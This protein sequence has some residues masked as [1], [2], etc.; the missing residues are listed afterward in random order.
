MNYRTPIGYVSR[1]N[2]SLYNDIPTK[3]IYQPYVYAFAR[4]IGERA[5]L[6]YIIDIGAGS[7]EKLIRF[8]DQFKIIAIDTPFGI[9]IARK[10]IPT[11]EFIVHDLE[12]GL[13]EIQIEIL[14]KSIIIFSDVIEHI[15]NPEKILRQLAEISR[16]APYIL[17]STPDRDRARG[18]LDMG[19]PANPAHVREWNGTEL[20]R[21]MLDCG[22]DDVP[23]YGHTINTDFHKAKSTLL[24]ISGSHATTKNENIHPDLKVVA[25]IH[26]FNES[27]IL[28]ET[29]NHLVQ[30]GI[31]VHYFDN[32]STDGSWELAHSFFE[33]GLIAHCERFPYAPTN[34]YEWHNQLEKTENYALQLNADWVMHHDVDEIRVS[35]WPELSLKDAIVHVDSLGFNAIDFTVIDFR[36]TKET[37]SVYEGFQES[38]NH[39]EFGRRSGHFVQIKCW[40]N[41]KRVSLADSGGH[42]ASFPGRNV[43]PLKFLLKHYPLRNKLQAEN[44]VFLNR[45][46]RFRKENES[47]GWHTQYNNFQNSN[48]IPGWLSSQL[49]PW[50]PIHFN[51]EF[52]VERLSGIGLKD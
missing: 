45:L 26:G 20:I 52:L 49:I 29:V 9:E 46:P 15:R 24:T 2:N 31:E 48:S 44:K 51:T 16:I 17:I 35:P 13:P 37:D 12:L 3:F 36:Y 41:N 8:I 39:F 34:Q 32:W 33:Q 42:E 18:W 38:L 6:E 43:F 30:Q 4:Y 47:F 25:V 10:I 5:N 27:D 1:T 7:G 50:H 28:K 22:F 21:F 40:K 19:P 23:F 14:K 11:A